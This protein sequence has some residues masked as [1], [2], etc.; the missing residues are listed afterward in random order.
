MRLQTVKVSHVL[1]LGLLITQTPASWASS[2]YG[3]SPT[4]RTNAETVT[5]ADSTESVSYTWTAPSLATTNSLGTLHVSARGQNHPDAEL[6]L[7]LSVQPTGGD[8][9]LGG[10]TRTQSLLPSGAVASTVFH[11]NFVADGSSVHVSINPRLFGR[12]LSLDIQADKGLIAAV[13]TATWPSSDNPQLVP[14][15]YYSGSAYHLQLPDV[16]ANLYFDWKNSSATQLN[17]TQAVYSPLTTGARNPIQESLIVSV[18]GSLVNVLP[19][20]RNPASPYLSQLAGRTVLDIW[21][22]S[23]ASI[24]Q[25]LNVLGNYGLHDCVAVIHIWQRSGYD[26]ALPSQYPANAA[27]G[28]DAGLKQAV[29]AGQAN[30]CY[31]AVHEN[32][33]DYY[34]NSDNF[35]ANAVA[36]D[37]QGNMQL[38]W[39]NPGTHIQSFGTRP[40]WYVTNAATQSP[41]IHS[42]YGTNADFL[43][44]NSAVL[45]WWRVDMDAAQP[46]AGKFSTLSSSS[47]ALWSFE[48]ANYGG[49]VLGEG[50]NHWYWSGL[51]DGA[52]AQLGAGTIPANINANAPLFVDFD[53]LKMHPLQVNHGMGYYERWSA[54]GQDITTRT[55]L[56]DAYRMQEVIYGHAPFIGNNNWTNTQRVLLEQNL[57]SPVAQRYGTATATNIQYQVNGAWTDSD[58]ATKAG[59]WTRVKVGYS[60]GDQFVANSTAQPL[61]WNGL[62]VPQ[63][64]WAA[65]GPNM[66]AYTAMN[67]TTIADYAHAGNTYFAN[68]RSAADL[69]EA[70]KVAQ[71]TAVAFQQTSTGSAQIQ[72]QWRALDAA[73]GEN[74]T[75]FVHIVGTTGTSAGQVVFGADHLLP[76]AT[77]TWTPGQ[78]VQDKFQINTPYGVPDGTYTLRM[79]LYSPASGARYPLL[80]NDDGTLRYTIGTLVISNSGANLSFQA[81]AQAPAPADPRLNADGHLVNFGALRTDG[82]VSLAETAGQWTLRSYP[83][84]RDVTVQ[85]NANSFSPAGLTCDAASNPV[86]APVLSN[87]YWQVHTGGASACHWAGH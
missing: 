76:I 82:M 84:S 85:L 86:P 31:V 67:G 72:V 11:L 68:A 66:L 21:G 9:R 43:D 47:T 69:Q 52:E 83:R 36:L 54:A 56:A 78:L 34:P 40:T 2:G 46:G 3:P 26:N 55:D 32:Y 48:R 42:L 59:N 13:N 57:V 35:T 10:I 45:P 75:N 62:T 1:I 28:G 71:P 24:A 17:P 5:Y 80:G 63:Y 53:L 60:N 81:A 65:S 12:S 77:N 27:Q 74:L 61:Q 44:V 8:L 18:S 33:V 4:P 87:G 41:E 50:A 23:F 49:P 22:G 79:G 25:T 19:D 51:L 15:P 37:S 20:P 14:V 38:S 6:D 39:L 7:P 64:G 58:S 29:A 30:G 16:F 73:I 70:G